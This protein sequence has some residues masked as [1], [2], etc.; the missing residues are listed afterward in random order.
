M[1]INIGGVSALVILAMVG[2][3]FVDAIVGGDVVQERAHAV[4]TMWL[5]ELL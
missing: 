1:G 4:F 3:N 2:Q 5:R